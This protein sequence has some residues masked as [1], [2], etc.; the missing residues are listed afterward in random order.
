MRNRRTYSSNY[1]TRTIL[2]PSQSSKCVPLMTKPI[3]SFSC[4]LDSTSSETH[5]HSQND[6]NNYAEKS[7]DKPFSKLGLSAHTRLKSSL[8]SIPL[9]LMKDINSLQ[10]T[11]ANGLASMFAWNW[12]KN[13]LMST[14]THI[15]Y[16]APIFNPRAPRMFIDLIWLNAPYT[17]LLPAK[18]ICLLWHIFAFYTQVRLLRHIFTSTSHVSLPW[19]IFASCGTYRLPRQTYSPFMAKASYDKQIAFHGKHTCLSQYKASYAKEI[20]FHDT[21]PFTTNILSFYDTKPPTT[22]K[23]AF[24]DTHSPSMTHRCLFRHIFAS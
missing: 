18:H 6:S 19:H 12:R 14:I 15:F 10:A 11:S 24:H 16:R 21:S 23:S 7:K 8:T 13:I 20:A 1:K 5:H 3:L 22:T 9:F 2:P 4:S 17:P